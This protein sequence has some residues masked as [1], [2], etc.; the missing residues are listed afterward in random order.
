[1]LLADN[2]HDNDY[3]Y[4][5][6][7]STVSL[8]WHGFRD[9]IKEGDG[10]RILTYLK[11][12]LMLFHA[13]KKRNQTVEALKQNQLLSEAHRT[14][15]LWSRTVNTLGRQGGNVPCDPTWNI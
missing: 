12:W 2:C 7:P 9:V 4:A 6:E 1:M 14:Q 13:S 5:R 3:K 11:F 15:L 10:Q 8:L